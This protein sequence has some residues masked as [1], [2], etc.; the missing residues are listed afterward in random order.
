[1]DGA[2][3]KGRAGLTSPP[4]FIKKKETHDEAAPRAGHLPA[5]GLFCEW[6]RAAGGK[7]AGGG[8]TGAPRGHP[9]PPWDPRLGS[10]P[11]FCPPF[12][13]TPRGHVGSHVRAH[14]THTHTHTRTHTHAHAHS[15]TRFF[16]PRL[17]FMP[18]RPAMQAAPTLPKA[19]QGPSDK[20]PAAAT[21]FLCQNAAP[22]PPAPRKAL[23]FHSLRGG[24]PHQAKIQKRIHSPKVMPGG[25]SCNQHPNTAGHLIQN[26]SVGLLSKQSFAAKPCKK[27]Q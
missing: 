3:G 2:R 11:A 6:G 13:R 26:S 15:C 19:P 4:P 20:T 24:A 21:L 27:C 8:S 7:R 23:C 22:K 12:T 18:D 16:V 10:H 9:R 14:S 17:S 5:R 1:M 25:P